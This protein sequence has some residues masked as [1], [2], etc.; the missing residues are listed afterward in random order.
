MTLDSSIILAIAGLVGLSFFYLL[1]KVFEYKSKLKKPEIVYVDTSGIKENPPK[2]IE[3]WQ[4][5]ALNIK[6]DDKHIITIPHFGS[7]VC[8]KHLNTITILYTALINKLD[9]K[10]VN[11][12]EE[13]ISLIQYRTIYKR[14]VKMVYDMCKP[15]VKNR[16]TKKAYFKRAKTD[17]LFILE[18]C[19][20]IVD[21]WSLVKK[22]LIYLATGKTLRQAQM[23]GSMS[24]VN[25]S[26]SD[27]Q[28][29]TSIKP[30]YAL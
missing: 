6:V 2:F 23:D 22:K 20:E 4:N 29:R 24:T 25:S 3:T 15:F 1:F 26:S 21:F 27:G 9:D 10:S 30:V 16:K 12:L 5:K 13:T 17:R 7:K 14:I 28:P 18:A 19:N 8:F 11:K